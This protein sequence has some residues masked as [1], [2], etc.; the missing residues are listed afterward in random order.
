MSESSFAVLGS[1][2]TPPPGPLPEAERGWKRSWLPSPLRGGAGGGVVFWV[3]LPMLLLASGCAIT[4]SSVCNEDK[5]PPPGMPC[6]I[7]VLWQNSIACAADPMNGGQMNP[8]LAGRLYLFGEKIDKPMPG[9]GALKVEMFDESQG[10]SV[11]VEEWTLYPDSLNQLLRRDMIGWGY[12]V[13]LPSGTLKPEMSKIR[14]R[15]CYQP[16][17]NATTLYAESIVTLADSNAVRHEEVKHVE[18]GPLP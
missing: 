10:H 17:P 2:R 14:M 8:G 5:P 3:L 18:L 4:E 11:K 16:K 6:Q 15:S 1:G 12:T 9:S 7:Q 13:F